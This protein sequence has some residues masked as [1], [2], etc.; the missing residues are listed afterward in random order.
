MGLEW[1]ATGYRV[2]DIEYN[3]MQEELNTIDTTYQ[4]VSDEPR[5]IEEHNRPED[6]QQPTKE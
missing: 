4:E 6:S 5:M 3:K 1:R 2:P